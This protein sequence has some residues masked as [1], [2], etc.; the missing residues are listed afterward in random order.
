MLRNSVVSQGIWVGWCPEGFMLPFSLQQQSLH[1]LCLQTHFGVDFPCKPGTVLPLHTNSHFCEKSG[2]ELF[3]VTLKGK[4]WPQRCQ[5]QQSSQTFLPNLWHLCF[6]LVLSS[7]LHVWFIL[8]Y[9]EFHMLVLLVWWVRSSGSPLGSFPA[10]WGF[11]FCFKSFLKA[12]IGHSYS[13]S[14]HTPFIQLKVWQFL[15]I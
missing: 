6:S 14:I 9:F 10:I 12:V 1:P 15:Y 4:S 8:I 5:C 11:G 2:P 13:V 7:V 3:D